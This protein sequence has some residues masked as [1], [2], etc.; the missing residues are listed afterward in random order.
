[1]SHVVTT[2]TTTTSM[3]VDQTNATAVLKRKKRQPKQP[4]EV[5]DS[6]T[7]TASSSSEPSPESFVLL[8]EPSSST[9]GGL[10]ITPE[11]TPK[12]SVTTE[13]YPINSDHRTQTEHTTSSLL[14]HPQESS[15][16]VKVNILSCREV[17]EF[18]ITATTKFQ[19]LRRQIA[20][21][22]GADDF[23][24][25]HPQTRRSVATENALINSKDSS[26]IVS[27]ATLVSL[28]AD[29]TIQDSDN[30]VIRENG[31]AVFKVGNF[32]H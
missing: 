20:L 13:K 4:I 22:L 18:S 32:A 23:S 30:S 16:L 5:L 15:R 28:L 24:F 1:M 17:G 21:K 8:P 12:E 26:I 2:T 7:A 9:H 11:I 29:T 31:T 19:D 10:T 3:S 25:Q 14:S 6:A 27:Q